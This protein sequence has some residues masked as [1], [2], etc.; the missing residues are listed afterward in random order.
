MIRRLTK[1]FI[2]F[3][4]LTFGTVAVWM[5]MPR[6]AAAHQTAESVVRRG[7][8]VLEVSVSG[9]IAAERNVEL[10]APISQDPHMFKI[11][12][13]APEGK[14]LQPG[15]MV[16]E[17]DSQEL[18]QKM[19][20]YQAEKSRIEEELRRRR[21]EYDIQ[22][23]D[24]KVA[25]EE[26]RVKAATARHKLLAPPEIISVH[27]RRL[28][29]IERDQA[30]QDAALLSAKGV[31]VE[32]MAAAEIRSL[33]TTLEQVR[34]RVQQTQSR[35]DACTVKAPIGGTLVYKVMS[36][37]AKR[38]VGEQTCHH[39]VT[40]QIPDMST[41]RLNAVI[42]ESSS[43]KVM[44][45][46]PVRVR[47]DALPDRSISG[48]VKSVGSILRMKRFDMP[49]KVVDAVIELEDVGGK[50]TPGMTATGHVEI[51]KAFGVLLIPLEFVRQSEGRT[52]V[53]VKGTGTAGWQE[54]AVQLGRRN[55]EMV[56]VLNGLREGQRVVK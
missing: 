1:W 34:Q 52:V 19:T 32:R 29:T 31:A 10:T 15:E 3:A 12:R 42:D 55:T 22:F 43:S 54:L 49:A 44:P 39:E 40:L 33:E 38:K 2:I 47:V 36:N 51:D 16:M 35:M 9:A 28:F 23:K 27:E 45:G 56:E 53:R 14:R 24:L 46:Q 11:A 4:T 26:A 21:L 8:L 20:D 30:D 50:L 6:P 13:M 7:D 48:K 25:G 37:G 18:R 5:R 17:L 41:L